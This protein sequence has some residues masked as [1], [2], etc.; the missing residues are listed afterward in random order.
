MTLLD[1]P[2]D[3]QISDTPAAAQ[4]AEQA[5][6]W[7]HALSIWSALRH[8]A[9]YEREALIGISTALWQTGRFT[10]AKAELEAATER[11]HDYLDFS[12]ARAL[13]A[14]QAGHHDEA[15]ALWRDLQERFPAYPLAYAK[16]TEALLKNHDYAAAEQVVSSAL[17]RFPSDLNLLV[18]AI[19]VSIAQSQWYEASLRLNHLEAA[20]PE[21]SFT[22]ISAPDLRRTI[23]TGQQIMQQN[24]LCG[25]A[26]EAE[27][28]GQWAAAQHLWQQLHDSGFD[29]RGTLLGLG[30]SSREGGDFVTAEAVLGRASQRF[31]DDLE[32]LAHHAQAAAKAEIWPV[33]AQRWQYIFSRFEIA[34]ELFA[35]LAANAYYNAG[36]TETAET[37]IKAAARAHPGRGEYHITCATFAQRAEHWP[38]AIAAWDEV[39]KLH[40]DAELFKSH[41]GEALYKASQSGAAAPRLPDAE[42]ELSALRQKLLVFESL[43]DNCEMGMV[44]RHY[45]VEPLGLLRFAAIRLDKVVQL[46]NQNFAGVGD[47]QYTII[48]ETPVEF[49][50]K[51]N[52]DLFLMHTYLQTHDIT[53]EK[54]LAQ[55]IK[56]IGFLRRELLEELETGDRI[57]VCKNSDWAIPDDQL[58]EIST[59]INKY[60][61]NLLLGI[62][63]ADEHNPPGSLKCVQADI[64]VG[65]VASMQGNSGF[66]GGATYDY[67]SWRLILEAAY[68][69]KQALQ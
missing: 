27:R 5:G 19:L 54:L 24:A 61:R 41:R 44:Q 48:E 39:I 22:R 32:I 15:L 56:R 29:E 1:T 58:A 40:P 13:A 18:N 57:F 51:D 37:F 2:D 64:L 68:D 26:Y 53:A 25:Q 6:D 33:A 47:P 28:Q 69:Y 52:R 60:G 36:E 38:E 55:Q 3:L 30:R 11:F 34:S 20:W 9:V 16:I 67:A 31:P 42:D 46:L 49:I 65:Y 21:H 43:G 10:E 8:T 35:D 62:R 14:E 45:G 12:I 7:R 17:T 66:L 23:K 59:C 50:I 63:L 4:A